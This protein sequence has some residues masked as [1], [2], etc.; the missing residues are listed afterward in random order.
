MTIMMEHESKLP[1][2]LDDLLFSGVSF[3]LGIIFQLECRSTCN[4]WHFYS[5][6][7]NKQCLVFENW[8]QCY[9]NMLY[10]YTQY[11]CMVFSTHYGMAFLETTILHTKPGFELCG[12]DSF[13]SPGGCGKWVN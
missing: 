3:Q 7:Y 4:F 11:I 10:I 1:I 12:I 2:L 6:T 9:I 13:G 5:N 8:D